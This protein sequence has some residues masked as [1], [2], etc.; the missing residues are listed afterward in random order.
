VHYVVEDQDELADME[1][2][3]VQLIFKGAPGAIH[4][5]KQLVED[6]K[7]REIDK[8]MQHLTSKRIADRRSSEEGKEGLDAFLNKRKPSWAE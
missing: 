7:F 6:V 3:L 8:H 2:H 4:A 1:E 5:A